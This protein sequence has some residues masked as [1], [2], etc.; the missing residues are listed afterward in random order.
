M[1]ENSEIEEITIE[2]WEK[3]SKFVVFPENK[4]DF[5]NS[6]RTLILNWLRE[7]ENQILKFILGKNKSPIWEGKNYK[8]IMNERDGLE[9]MICVSR[10]RNKGGIDLKTADE[11]FKWGF[12]YN[13]PRTINDKES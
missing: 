7:H 9:K 1:V 13:F 12:G 2:E 3:L 10:H 4:S 8:E 11:I 6:F 5:V